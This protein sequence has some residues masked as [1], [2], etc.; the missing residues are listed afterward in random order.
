MRTVS[1]Q[2]NKVYQASTSGV[3]TT[4]SQ[5]VPN[6]KEGDRHCFKCGDKSHIAKNC[7]VREYKCFKCNQIGH[8]AFECG[9]NKDERRPKP[10]NNVNVIVDSVKIEDEKK[11]NFFVKALSYKDFKVNALIDSGCNI[12]LMRKDIFDKLPNKNLVH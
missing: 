1:K 4:S 5:I 7:S 2:P 10:E 8:R 6:K 12:S 3:K 11:S 9:K